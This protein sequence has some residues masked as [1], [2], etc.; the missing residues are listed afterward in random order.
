MTCIKGSAVPAHLVATNC[1]SQYNAIKKKKTIDLSATGNPNTNNLL[2]LLQCQSKTTRECKEKGQEYTMCHNS[3][4]GV[5]TY[6]G[7][8]NCGK[9]MNEFYQCLLQMGEQ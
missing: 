9:E 2:L 1:T 8:K 5:G 7:K 3:F 4:M 6:K